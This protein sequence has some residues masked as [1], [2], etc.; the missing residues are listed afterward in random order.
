MKCLRTLPAVLVMLFASASAFAQEAGQQ[1]SQQV[2]VAAQLPLQFL[3]Y[4]PE[5]YDQQE[6]WP[7]LL[8]LH[9]MG[10]RGSDLKLVKVHGPPKLIA[11][12]KHFPMIVVSPQC[13]DW[14]RWEMSDLDTLLRYIESKY[15]VDSDRV[16]VSGL[17]MGGYGTW[18]LATN[19]PNRFAAIVPICG[20]GEAKAASRIAHIPTWV[21][22]GGDDTAVPVRGSTEMIKALQKAGGNPKFTFYPLAGHDS[23][24]EAY[25]TP[26]LYEWLLAQKRQPRNDTARGR[27]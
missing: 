13:P 7:L 19:Y 2:E 1:V 4:L 22:H 24:T 9:G 16:Y 11:A 23:W 12:G 21:F 27:F 18:Q 15:K 10:E 20:A 14:R 3:L 5:N 17:S 8:F 6:Q 26:E 25:N